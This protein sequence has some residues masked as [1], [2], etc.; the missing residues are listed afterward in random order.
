MEDLDE[1]GLR[2]RKDKLSSRPKQWIRDF[3]T[4]P[5]PWILALDYRI[6]TKNKFFIIEGNLQVVI[7]FILAVLAC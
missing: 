2:K 6:P 3:D 4:H 5:N 7:W 1:N